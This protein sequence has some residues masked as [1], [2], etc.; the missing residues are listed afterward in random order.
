MAAPLSRDCEFLGELVRG[1]RP[2]ASRARL[3]PRRRGRARSSRRR[4]L[5]SGQDREA[6]ARVAVLW[7]ADRA[8][9]DEQDAAVSCTHGLWVC[10]K[11]STSASA[12]AAI[13][14]KVRAGLSSNRYSFTFAATRARAARASAE[15][16]AQVEGELV[17]ERLRAL[18][19]VRECPVDRQLPD[20]ALVRVT[21]GAAAILEVAGD[22]VVVVAIDRRNATLLDQGA[23]LVRVGPVADQVAAAVDP[24][25]RAL[26]SAPA[27]PSAKAGW[28]GCR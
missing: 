2:V 17:H 20:L 4:R 8:A 15:L 26:R 27:P 16:E 1:A 25:S 21:V 5:R 7:F 14:S 6:G 12:S 13:R 23:D 11:T 10:P 24:R 22:R 28:R 19:G 9:V 3:R 18:V